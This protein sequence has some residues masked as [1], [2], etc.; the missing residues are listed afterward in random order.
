MLNPFYNRGE[1]RV[2]SFWR[3][4]IQGVLYVAGTILFGIALGVGVVLWLLASGQVT[5]AQMQDARVLSPLIS[6]ALNEL[7]GLNLLSALVSFVLLLGTVALAGRFLDHRPFKDFGFHWNGAWRR[8][9]GFGLA[10]GALLML[11]IFGVEWAAG[12]VTI[13]GLFQSREN[14]FAL[15]ILQG[16]ISFI[17]VGVYEELFSRGYQLRNLA[18]GLNWRWFG[19]RGA[20]VLAYLLSSLVFGFL[21]WLNPNSTLWTTLNLVLAGLFLGL[22]LILTGELA[23]GIGIHITWNFFQGYVFGLP[24]SGIAISASL[25]GIR[26]SGP[27]LWTGGAFGPEGGLM[28]ILA[29]LVGVAFIL[30]WVRY[31]RG[32]I[33]LDERLAGYV[34]PGAPAGDQ[35][36]TGKSSTRPPD[37]FPIVFK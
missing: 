1:H 34:R 31:T 18:E 4:L 35:T 5:P 27:E 15:A 20:L 30:L 17:F 37:H 9:F 14:N 22:G 25:I 6:R 33:A 28:G 11:G 24:V 29:I 3:V 26:Q 8:D 19:P 13:T 12:W 7:P 16:A 36:V 23:I 2:R 21:H 32:R 10:L